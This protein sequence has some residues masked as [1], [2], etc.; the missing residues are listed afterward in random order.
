MNF[1]TNITKYPYIRARD[2][3]GGKIQTDDLIYI[4]ETVYSKIKKYIIK[5]GDIVI[6]IVGASVGDVSYAQEEVDGFNLTENA[7]RLTNFNSNVNGR[8]LFYLLSMKQYR[9]YMQTVA[10]GA[11]QPKLG[12]YKVERIKVKL[13]KIVT[14]NRVA[15]LLSSIDRAIDNNTLRIKQLEQMAEN[16]YKEWFVRFRFPGH[17]KVEMENGLPKGWNIAPLSSEYNTTSGGTP[18][19]TNMSYYSGSIPWIKTGELQGTFILDTEEY[20]TEEAVRKS[21]A[22]LI[23]AYSLLIAMYAGA[24]VG[25]LGINSTLATCNQACCVITTK[26][27][28]PLYYLLYFLQAQKGFLQSIS[29]G[30]AQQNIS[31]DIIKKLKVLLPPIELCETFNKI[32]SPY[33][34]QCELLM[35]QNSL[36]TRQRDLLLPRL[37]SGKIAVNA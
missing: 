17:E 12:I 3:K 37:M 5:S 1:T 28:Y 33:L 19:R 22:K 24:N 27:R 7:V 34:Q 2:I 31:Q 36:L 8:Y 21:S 14:Q 9:D 6:T 18:S 20:I 32:V 10:G 13:P 23:P 15:T 26:G 4:D 11:A 30:A 29:F 16:L 25:N 35:K